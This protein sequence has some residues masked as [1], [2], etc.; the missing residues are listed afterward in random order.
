MPADR[1][2]HLKLGH[3][4]KVGQLTDLE[5]RVWVQ[6]ILSADDFGVMRASAVT[7]TT[8]AR[9]RSVISA[10]ALLICTVELPSRAR[11]PLSWSWVRSITSSPLNWL[12]A[13][14]DGSPGAW[15]ARG[16]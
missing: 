5:F 16:T 9:P 6:Y 11:T 15:E 4:E 3:S 13:G 12:K 10:S 1:L 7:L 8:L 2:F 14:H